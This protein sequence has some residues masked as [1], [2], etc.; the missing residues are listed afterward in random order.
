MDFTNMG[1]K[2]LTVMA[3]MSAVASLL[4]GRTAKR[5]LYWGIAWFTTLTKTKQDDKLLPD[6]RKDW[7][8]PNDTNEEK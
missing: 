3:G 8:L 4:L 6:I 1:W 5:V 2:E 7:D